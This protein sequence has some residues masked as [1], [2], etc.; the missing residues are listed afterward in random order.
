MSK[1]IVIC[2][3]GTNNDPTRGRTNVSRFFR[4]LDKS[5]SDQI[6]YYQPGIGTLDPDNPAG[7]LRQTIRRIWDLATASFFRRHVTSAYRYLMQVYE[8]G[9]RLFLIGF[10]R[11][12]YTCRVLAGMIHK[13]GL[14]YRG[15]EEMVPFAWEIYRTRRNEESA[16][17]F[18]RYYSRRIDID[19][20][21]VWDTVSSI[22]SR[23]RPKVF[24]S[25]FDNP[26]VCSFRHA[27]ALDERRAAYGTN[28]WT[29][30]PTESQSVKQV[31]FA[32]AHADIGGGYTADTSP[33][34]GAIPL[35]WMI[36]EAKAA[37]LN[38]LH[39]EEARLFWRDGGHAPDEITIQAV[40]E[41]FIGYESHD[42]LTRPDLLGALW[43]FV[44]RVPLPRHYKN[45][46]GSWEKKWRP[47]RGA[48]RFV[49]GHT[50]IH[51]SVYLRMAQNSTPTTYQPVNIP[52]TPNP[53]RV[54]W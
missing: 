24:P 4:M 35:L 25:T 11:G 30:Q 45:D 32:G 26:S 34:L 37:G 13:V 44:E 18:R 12:A 27:V 9:D 40:T 21:G 41:R 39:Q 54:C 53:E 1:N 38:F 23:F 2:I 46:A 33:G 47:H 28:L 3:D 49:P 15:Q 52:A 5:A 48:P 42:E 7:R 51:H 50:M 17:R 6:G 10:S 43:R 36:C 22:G 16:G 20:L 14:L 31:W 19:F 29:D 8:P